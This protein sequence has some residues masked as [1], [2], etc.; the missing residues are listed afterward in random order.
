MFIDDQFKQTKKTSRF[1]YNSQVSKI[2][3]QIDSNR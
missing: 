2:E 1:I 3:L